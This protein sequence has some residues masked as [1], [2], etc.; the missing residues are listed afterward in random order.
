MMNWNEKYQGWALVTGASAGLGACFV[1][2]IAAR[3]MPVILVA[4]REDRLKELAAEV[5]EKH[6]V[7]T[8]CIP[9]DLTRDNMLETLTEQVGDRP[10]GLLVNNAGFGLAKPFHTSDPEWLEGMVNLNCRVPTVLT[11]H[12]LPPMIERGRGAHILL[13]SVAAFQPVGHFGVYSATKTYNLMLGEA[14]W[15]EQRSLGIDTLTLAPGIT[16]TE[17][18]EVSG[19]HA[20]TKPADPQVVVEKT[21]KALGKKHVVVP[22]IDNKIAVQLARVLPRRTLAGFVEWLG[23]R[24]LSPEIRDRYLAERKK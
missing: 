23:R 21:L 14:L 15:S 13:A 4:R 12:F 16:A 20:L 6:G 24:L 22:G 1:R 3:N 5:A 2:A 9:L 19:T 17:F 18:Q 8:L 11:R 7:E 10:V